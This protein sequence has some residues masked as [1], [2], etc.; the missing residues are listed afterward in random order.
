M[1]LKFLF[2][3]FVI[4]ILANTQPVFAQT[5]TAPQI[6]LTWQAH[7]YLPSGYQGKALPPRDSTVDVYLEFLDNDKIMPLDKNFIRY[8]VNDRFLAAGVGLKKVSFTLNQFTARNYVVTATVKEY[9]GSDTAG[10][11]RGDTKDIK[12]SVVINRVDPLVVINAPIARN[13]IKTNTATLTALPYF[14]KSLNPSDLVFIWKVNNAFVEGF[15]SNLTLTLQP[16]AEPQTLFVS[17][18][19]ANRD[20]SVESATASEKFIIQK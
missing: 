17:V 13:Q 11:I 20:N 8:E 6:I 3:L 18:T 15:L 4:S 7:S 16:S 5:N 9:R 14:F 2:A 19:A 1:S 10:D 12:K